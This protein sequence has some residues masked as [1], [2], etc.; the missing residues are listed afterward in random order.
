MELLKGQ[1]RF[2]SEHF[3]VVG[4]AADAGQLQQVAQREGIRVVDVPMCREISL[5]NDLKSLVALYRL[6]RRERPD[7]VHA[8]TPKASLLAMI[9]GRMAR[10]PHRL[11]LVTGLRYQGAD[12]LFR[13][14]LMTMERLSCRFAT[15]V[16]PEGQGVR[17]ALM[18]D[19]IC[20]QPSAVIHHGNIN[21]IDTTVFA[22]D[23]VADDKAAIRH[24]LGL[25]ADDFVFIFIGRIVRDKGMHELVQAMRSFPEEGN[26]RLLLLGSFEEALD[27]LPAADVDFLKTDRRVVFAGWQT[28]VRPFL[29]AA[30]VLVFPSYREGFPNVPMQ[31]GAMG[32]PSIVTDINGCNEIITDGVNG[33]IIPSHDEQA[34]TAAMQHLS[35]HPEEVQLLA[36]K[37]RTMICE[38]YEQRELWQA[39]LQMYNSL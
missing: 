7:I 19:G 32:L 12:G 4:V 26:V 15:K 10:V 30:D 13:R 5:W 36:S 37:A 33:V 6:F 24:R 38:R 27:P 3:D 25:S 23:A 14:L 21:G 29:K 1:L 16:I 31:A 9:A 8:N 28:D 22:A 35:N 18:S 39:L 2:L 11:Y 20:K 34:L 17:R